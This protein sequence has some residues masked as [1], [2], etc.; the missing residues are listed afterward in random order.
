MGEKRGLPRPAAQG[1]PLLLRDRPE[2]PSLAATAHRH[3]RLASRMID[4]PPREDLR[5]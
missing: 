3:F 1:Q 4:Q 2:S 5:S